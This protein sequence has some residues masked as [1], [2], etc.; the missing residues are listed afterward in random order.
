MAEQS[1][2]APEAAKAKIEG[3]SADRHREGDDPDVEL[4]A[5]SG[6]LASQS[7]TL[8]DLV[9]FFHVAQVIGP[10]EYHEG[11]DD[12]AFTN[13]MARENL[14]RAASAVEAAPEEAA[15]LGAGPDEVRSW[16]RIA[17]AMVLGQDARTGLIEQFTGF[18]GLEEVDLATLGVRGAP[19]DMILGHA[20]L[21][22]AE[23]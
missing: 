23:V 3:K 13:W 9:G 6:D 12:N 7:A 10:D 11:V 16:R 17:D 15:Q 22:P 4:A 18:F 5:T 8:Q 21:A 14:R 20:A 19:A 1:G 2:G